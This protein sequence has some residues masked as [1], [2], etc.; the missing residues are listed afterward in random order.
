V[1]PSALPGASERR[2]R[3]DFLQPRLIR[4]VPLLEYAA[5]GFR[6]GE[7]ASGGTHLSMHRFTLHQEA[8]LVGSWTHRHMMKSLMRKLVQHLLHAE[9]Y[10]LSV[11]CAFFLSAQ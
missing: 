3:T 9:L 1:Y 6:T 5:P 10:S 4:P 2:T 11:T 8:A 7:F